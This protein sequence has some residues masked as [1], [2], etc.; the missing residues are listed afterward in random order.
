MQSLVPALCAQ[1]IWHG[2][3]AQHCA[4]LSRGRI[5][6]HNLDGEGVRDGFQ[7]SPRAGS[8]AGRRFLS[9]TLWCCGLAVQGREGSGAGGPSSGRRCEQRPLELILIPCSVSCLQSLVGCGPLAP[10]L[11]GL[12]QLSLEHDAFPWALL[13]RAGFAQYRLSKKTQTNKTALFFL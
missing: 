6:N 4:V 11:L 7:L 13:H 10:A 1:T 12:K 3:P 9:K 2:L 5:V 8:S